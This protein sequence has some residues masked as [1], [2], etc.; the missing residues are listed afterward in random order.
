MNNN[1]KKH[2]RLYGTI[3]ATISLA[4]AAFYIIITPEEA[5]AASGL[6]RLILFMGT[7]FA[8]FC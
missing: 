5:S 1:L 4:I 6:Q 2:R 7:H 3:G 8:G